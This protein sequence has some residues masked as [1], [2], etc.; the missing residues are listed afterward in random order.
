[1]KRQAAVRPEW[2]LKTTTVK[3]SVAEWYVL[4]AFVHLV[5]EDRSRH[6][7]LRSMQAIDLVQDWDTVVDSVSRK[8]ARPRWRDDS[9]DLSPDEIMAD[10]RRTLAE[11]MPPT[12]PTCR[13]RLSIERLPE[14]ARSSGKVIEFPAN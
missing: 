8:L 7:L 4:S 10:L 13:L 3:L 11:P 14:P 1:M 6:A 12:E 9:P 2:D 5:E